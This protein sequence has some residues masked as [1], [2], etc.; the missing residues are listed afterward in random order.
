MCEDMGGGSSGE[1]EVLTQ[2]CGLSKEFSCCIYNCLG[3]T[4]QLKNLILT[5]KALRVCWK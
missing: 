3:N 1:G 2:A 5:F 4:Y